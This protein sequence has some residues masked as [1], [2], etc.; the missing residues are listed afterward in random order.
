MN[1]LQRYGDFGL[2]RFLSELLRQGERIAT[3]YGNRGWSCRKIVFLP[4]S[5]EEWIVCF[6]FASLKLYN[7][8]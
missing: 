4:R 2:I 5:L 1:L 6:I 8:E 7:K 3:E